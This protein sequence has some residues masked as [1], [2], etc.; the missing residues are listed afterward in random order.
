MMAILLK[1]LALPVTAPTQGLLAVLRAIH[2]EVDAA[3]YDPD[4]L[5]AELAHLQTLVDAGE[6][7]EAEYAAL[8]ADLLDRLEVA[9]RRQR[10]E[11]A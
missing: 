3:L 5:R 2:R 1:L 6:L 11:E 7:D 8:E 9:Q 4:Q 10:G